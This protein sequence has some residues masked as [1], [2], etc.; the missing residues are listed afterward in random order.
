MNILFVNTIQYNINGIANVIFEYIKNFQILKSN[1][2]IFL[3]SYGYFDNKYKEIATNTDAKILVLPSRKHVLKY[4]NALK[5][6]IKE[7]KIDIVHINGNSST[8]VLEALCCKVSGVKFICH[9]HN[10]DCSHKITHKLLQPFLRSISKNNLACSTETGKFAFRKNF[11]VFFNG[12]EIEKFLFSDID[13]FNLRKMYGIDKNELVLLHVG[14][15]NDQKNQEFLL[16]VLPRINRPFKMI[17]VG[18]GANLQ[19][20][21]LLANKLKLNGKIIFAGEQREINKYYSCADLFLFPS[22]FEGFGIVLIEAQFN[23]LKC[24]CSDAVTKDVNI[25]NH[26]I[27][28]ELNA[29]KWSKLINSE[30]QRDFYK[31]INDIPNNYYE[32]FSSLKITKKLFN[33]YN[34]LI[35]KKKNDFC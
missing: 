31:N 7:N 13:C 10:N 11:N 35:K 26:I 19:R 15:F 27:Y 16:N 29:D 6:I 8:M 34:S 30:I 1:L 5:N 24:I 28:T 33:Y 22:I 18:D 3:S 9:A 21:K 12:I 25:N 4:V 17:F 23:G 20:C 32:K 14:V 2:N